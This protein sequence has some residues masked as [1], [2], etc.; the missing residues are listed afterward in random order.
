MNIYKDLKKKCIQTTY[1]QQQTNEIFRNKDCFISVEHIRDCL[2]GKIKC[3]NKNMS[4]FKR[5]KLYAENIQRIY[6]F[7]HKNKVCK[8]EPHCQNI[9]TKFLAHSM[10]VNNK[11]P[12]ISSY[13]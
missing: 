3:T 12:I 6:N 2:N 7:S 5:E 9:K 11:F 4:A 1:N 8:N 13:L 10:F